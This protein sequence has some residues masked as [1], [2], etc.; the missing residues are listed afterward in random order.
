MKSRGSAQHFVVASDRTLEIVCAD[1]NMGKNARHVVR[2]LDAPQFSLF[3]LVV[4]I[5]V[6]CKL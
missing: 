3:T 4:K 6:F 2:H 5:G 1:R